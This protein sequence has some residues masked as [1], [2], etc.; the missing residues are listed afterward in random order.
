MSFKLP[1][2]G[3]IHSDNPIEIWN[4]P[5]DIV[6]LILGHIP[7]IEIYLFQE[8]NS[9]WKQNILHQ[10]IW[11]QKCVAESLWFPYEPPPT[12]WFEYFVFC[13]APNLLPWPFSI[14]P[15][16][17]PKFHVN[18]SK[19]YQVIHLSTNLP[20]E[21]KLLN[22]QGALTFSKPPK[23]TNAKYK[24]FRRKRYFGLFVYE[25]NEFMAS[26]D[27]KQTPFQKIQKKMPE[28]FGNEK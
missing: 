8:I 14:P 13:N 24:Y 7:A 18:V 19:K 22:Q 3:F 5:S 20:I 6:S 12:N 21:L 15:D 4:L 16:W 28:H 17:V 23:G 25:K 26:V 1:F 27:M 2:S 11:R 9:V 10:E